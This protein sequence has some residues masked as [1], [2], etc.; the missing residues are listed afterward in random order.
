MKKKI[1]IIDDDRDILALVKLALQADYEVI[2]QSF[3]SDIQETCSLYQPDLVLIDLK[4]PGVD[5]YELCGRIREFS[6]D[7]PVILITGVE[8]K[9]LKNNY[10][11]IRANDY[12]LKPF[13]LKAL[14]EKVEKALE[15]SVKIS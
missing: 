7:L 6:P 8:M 13:D 9:A 3:C 15:A 12:L 11:I 4:L 5:G 1:L 2:P 10:S 14:R